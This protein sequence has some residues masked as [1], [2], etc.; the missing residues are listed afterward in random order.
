MSNHLARAVKRAVEK[1]LVDEPHENEVL[2][3]LA[4]RLPI[5]RR[6]RD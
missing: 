3:A 5:E 2:F 4:G 6:P 1:C